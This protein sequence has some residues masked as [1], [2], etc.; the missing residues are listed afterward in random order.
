MRPSSPAADERRYAA[1]PLVEERS[2]PLV[3]ERSLP[4]VE[5]RS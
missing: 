5:E 3:E 2:L 4:L 1:L